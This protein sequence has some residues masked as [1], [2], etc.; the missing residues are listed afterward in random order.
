M[1]Y[2]VQHNNAIG[3]YKGG[4]RF[5]SSVNLSILKFLAFEQTFKN[6][7]TTLPMGGGKGG[8]DFS[9]RGKSN[10]EVMRFVQSF[11]LELFWRYIGPETD[12][13]K[14][15]TSVLADAKLVSCSVCIKNSLVNLQVP[16][17]IGSDD[18]LIAYDKSGKIKRVLSKKG[19]DPQSY[20]FLG[21]FT[22]WPNGDILISS[23]GDVTTYSNSFK[24]IR[25]WSDHE[26]IGLIEAIILFNDSSYIIKC[27]PTERQLRYRIINHKNGTYIS[28]YDS[29]E[30][31]NKY[32]SSF[33]F[34]ICTMN[35]C[36]I[37]NIYLIPNSYRINITSYYRIKPNTTI[38]TK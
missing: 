6:S 36:S 11:M 33:T 10:G 32:I 37:L 3:P 29:I 25:K 20:S 15:V 7:L 30:K 24:F 18:I 22:I 1:G 17:Y 16:L 4:I 21:N 5:H 14:P 35:Y 8:S 31:Q 12:V 19:E 34:L 28:T 26:N 27:T 23:S 9:P 38:G 13:P 2:R